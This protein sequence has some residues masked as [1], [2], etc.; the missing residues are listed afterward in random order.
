MAQC[1]LAPGHVPQQLGV[2]VPA[3]IDGARAG[4]ETRVEQ[5]AVEFALGQHSSK[6]AAVQKL[7]YELWDEEMAAAS[8]T[9]AAAARALGK[10]RHHEF[11]LP[12]PLLECKCRFLNKK[13][14]LGRNPSL[15]TF[16]CQLH[17][18]VKCDVI[19]RH[20]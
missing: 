8:K 19:M 7:C 16:E 9:A 2:R 3:G 11:R 17:A 12:F 18:K 15:S 10:F 20:K 4:C 1:R 6:V 13:L 5:S 14:F